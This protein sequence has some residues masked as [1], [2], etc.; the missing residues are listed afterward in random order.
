LTALEAAGADQS[1][2]GALLE[3]SGLE[4]E[5]RTANGI[6]YALRGVDLRLE[7][8][9]V[10]AILGESGS[11]KSVTARAILGIL[12]SPPGFIRAGAIHFRGKDLLKM[13]P[14]E[15][16]R[17]IGPSIAMV[18]QDALAAL[19]PVYSIGWQI[20]E[21][22]RVHQG[23]PWREGRKRAIELLRQVGIPSP[24]TRVNQY[25]HEFSGGM[26]QRVMIALAIALQPELL[27]A[28]E[29]TTALDVTVQAQ[30][31]QLLTRLRRRHGMGMI[32]ITHD[33]A[34]ASEVA[35]RVA[36]MYAGKVVEEAPVREILGNP[37]H[38]YS[39]ALIG[40]ADH[41]LEPRPEPIEGSPPDMTSPP[42][43]CA[44]HP[45]CSLAIDICRTVQPQ[46]RRAGDGHRS[47]CHRLEDVPHV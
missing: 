14:A 44:F 42:D 9:Q 35:D 4:V 7:G 24:E 32:L 36:V 41:S 28:D 25:V 5:F 11:G 27:I 30:I 1:L 26:R 18:F 39:R 40:L 46:L 20:A 29:P 6:A 33:I 31:M 38:P 15:R 17:L 47:A 43:G 19:N 13:R 45:R 16:R 34:V 10:L 37:R 23:M 3:V 2:Q 12:Q 21:C 8:G 22:F